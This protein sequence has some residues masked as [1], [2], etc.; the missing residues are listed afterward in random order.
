MQR[1]EDIKFIKEYLDSIEEDNIK[2][3]AII[4]LANHTMD[5]NISTDKNNSHQ[6]NWI[7]RKSGKGFDEDLRTLCKYIENIDNT[8]KGE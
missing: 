6:I 2:Y 3:E 5:I 4:T 1:D 7:N 8:N